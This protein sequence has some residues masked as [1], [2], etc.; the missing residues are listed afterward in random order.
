MKLQTDHLSVDTIDMS[1]AKAAMRRRIRADRSARSPEQRRADALALVSVVREL[2][3]I[4][5]ADCISLYASMPSEPGTTELRTALASAGLRVL[6]PIVLQDGKLE[7]AE[8]RGPL[9]P[10]RGLGGPEPTGPRLGLT[11]I[12]QAKV[13]LIPALAVD[14]LGHR[15]GQGAGY[16]DRVL[17]MVDP[18]VPVVAIVHEGEVLDAAVEPVPVEPHDRPVHAVVTPRRCLRI[19]Y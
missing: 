11:A 12:R 3:E 6:L 15:L 9:R 7:W 14:T 17:P 13:L 19:T 1:A 2:P 8:D 10:V 18:L 16:Y 5:A 4:Q